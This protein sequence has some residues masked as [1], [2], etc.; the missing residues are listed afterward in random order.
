MI[1]LIISLIA[2]SFFAIAITAF[3]KDENDKWKQ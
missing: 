1:V 3:H 2:V